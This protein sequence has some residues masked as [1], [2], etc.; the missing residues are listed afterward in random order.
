LPLGMPQEAAT[1]RLRIRIMF[2]NC[3]ELWGFEPQTSCMPCGSVASAWVGWS[4]TGSLPPAR[5]VRVR[6]RVSE[7]AYMWWLPF[8][9]PVVTYGGTVAHP[10]SRVDIL[11][12]RLASAPSGTSAGGNHTSHCVGSPGRYSVC[13]AGSGGRPAAACLAAAPA[14]PGSPARPH[15]ATGPS[16]GRPHITS[17][18]ASHFA[19]VVLAESCFRDLLKCAW[20]FLCPNPSGDS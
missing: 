5:T 12:Q 16:G 6:R 18:R 1:D 19:A 14:A 3:V 8:L 11:D 7:G 9:A 20:V 15:P 4:R 10:I 2:L 13:D 17:P